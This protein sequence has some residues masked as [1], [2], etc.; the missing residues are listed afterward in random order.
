MEEGIIF[1]ER[2]IR[3]EQTKK[4]RPS[5]PILFYDNTLY[6]HSK[7]ALVPGGK[8]ITTSFENL[9][10]EFNS[11]Y[12]LAE[13][14][15]MVEKMCGALVRAVIKAGSTTFEYF[16][17]T[18]LGGCFHGIEYETHALLT[19]DVLC[20]QIESAQIKFI[21]IPTFDKGFRSELYKLDGDSDIDPASSVSIRREWPK[22][23]VA[24]LRVEKPITGVKYFIPYSDVNS[25]ETGE[26]LISLSYPGPPDNAWIKKVYAN[27]DEPT[28]TEL[29]DSF[30]GYWDTRSAA[31]GCLVAQN[32]KLI[33][34][35]CSTT[36]GSSGGAIV[37]AKNPQLVVGIHVSGFM[38][39][40]YNLAVSVANPGF[41]VQYAK[42]VVPTLPLPLAPE[43]VS[44]LK[45]HVDVLKKFATLLPEDLINLIK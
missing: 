1:A 36:H 31:P 13:N 26:P 35:T 41:V 7:H 16:S 40:K 39:S 3:D 38:D 14:K 8:T 10:H 11:Y 34:H 28:L 24:F 42:F 23:D 20:P 29:A 30:G 6:L 43:V 21:G 22:H 5:F 4:L 25:L 33:A 2:A 37:L 15:E 18:V 27:G 45:E 17:P 44:Y 19:P 9:T 12:L 32:R